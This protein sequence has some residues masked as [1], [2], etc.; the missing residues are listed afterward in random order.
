MT[1]N[2]AATIVQAW[3]DAANAQDIPRLLQ[4]SAPEIEIAG[5]RGSGHGH[6]L[7]RDWLARAGLQ[8]QTRRIFARN[9]VVVADQQG[10]WRAPDT[11]SV[12][13][14]QAVASAFHVAAG[15]VTRVA[16]HDHLASALAEAGLEEGDEIA[17]S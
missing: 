17:A 9:E 6:Q 8:L 5:P 13:G 3:Q 4:L 16:R 1:R 7:L 2:S 14:E 10:I 12:I 15:R 11:G